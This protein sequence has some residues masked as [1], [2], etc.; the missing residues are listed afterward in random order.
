MNKYFKFLKYTEALVQ[1]L[2]LSDALISCSACAL[3]AFGRSVACAASLLFWPRKK[4]RRKRLTIFRF[5]NLYIYYMHCRRRLAFHFHCHCHRHSPPESHTYA[6]PGPIFRC[7]LPHSNKVELPSFS[8]FSR[9][10]FAVL[11]FFILFSSFFCCVCQAA[12][13]TMPVLFALLLAN[14]RMC[15][16]YFYLYFRILALLHIT[17]T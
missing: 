7:F 4:K 5:A 1:S 13:P 17:H 9:H 8:R 2:P 16:S 6:F 10:L 3:K 14:A 12:T 15:P 11:F